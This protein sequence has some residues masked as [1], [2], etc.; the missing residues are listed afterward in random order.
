MKYTMI[1]AFFLMAGF[2]I[3]PFIRAQNKVRECKEVKLFED[4]RGFVL[5]EVATGET[6]YGIST[7]YGTSVEKIKAANPE[8][9]NDRIEIGQLIAIDPD[10]IDKSLIHIIKIKKPRVSIQTDKPTMGKIDTQP[11]THLVKKGETLFSI[12]QKYKFPIDSLK[13]WNG[14]K[15][16]EIQLGQIIFLKNVNENAFPARQVIA[17]ET[18][19]ITTGI[20]KEDIPSSNI[21]SEKT[22]P[23]S[24]LPNPKTSTPANTPLPTI[25]GPPSATEKVS[26]KG[27]PFADLSSPELSSDPA[28]IE[29][30]IQKEDNLF[31]IARKFKV[32]V[33]DLK[34][35]NKLDTEKVK[36]DQLLIVG[37][38]HGVSAKENPV[39][40]TIPPQ[41]SAPKVNIEMTHIEKIVEDQNRFFKDQYLQKG[42]SPRGYEMM[43]A[44]GPA[45][46]MLGDIS[47]D[48]NLFILHKSA[49][50][51]SIVKLRNVANMKIC[52]AKVIGRLPSIAENSNVEMKVT[53]GVVKKLNLRG[54]R[55]PLECTWYAKD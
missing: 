8:I 18:E 13:K 11:F 33:A 51:Q 52:Y 29:Y 20:K 28:P 5:H 12:S 31:R 7:C 35:W 55:F 3:P 54:K 50:V 23:V 40:A 44:T 2:I 15:D 25:P 14:T 34:K 37:F 32:S 46:W 6:L 30:R 27:D 45:T 16:G 1:F 36:V 53:S 10:E 38:G 26:G 39:S 21:S 24:P 47:H 22:K 17:R 42:G 48:Q 43:K 41:P 19:T 4:E 49:P 9:T